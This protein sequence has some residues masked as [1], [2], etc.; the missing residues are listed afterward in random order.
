MSG[1]A[2]SSISNTATVA[3]LVTGD[4]VPSD[5]VDVA[6]GLVADGRRLPTAGANVGVLIATA[7]ALL[8]VGAAMVMLSTRRRRPA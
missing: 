1:T 7:F 6:T 3:S 8:L 4:V 2:Q 5:N